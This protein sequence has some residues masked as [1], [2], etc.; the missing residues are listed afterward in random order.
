[1]YQP[2]PLPASLTIVLGA[3]APDDARQLFAAF[4]FAAAAHAEHTRDE[5]TPYIDHPARVADILWS[6]LGC[7]DVDVLAAALTHDVLEDC[8]WI[9]PDILSGVI[10][11]RA[12]ALVTAVTK[13]RVP[14][15]AKPAR[16]RA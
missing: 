14:E 12:L 15:N 13:A 7:R 3:L 6:E 9:T 5:G 16:D 10:G 4:Q 2:A 8:D 1:M 11:A